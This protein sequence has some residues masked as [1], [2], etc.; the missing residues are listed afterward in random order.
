MRTPGPPPPSLLRV[1]VRQEGLLGSRQ[2]DAAGVTA[3]RRETLRCA[4]VLVPVVRGVHDAAALLPEL[5]RGPDHVR[6]RAAWLALLALG[7]DRAVATGLCALALH[8]VHGLPRRIRPEAALPDGSHRRPGGGILVRGVDPQPVVRVGGARAC[9]VAQ[10][11]ADAVG[12]LPRDSAVA[13]LDSAVHLGLL[14]CADLA[15]VRSLLAGRRGCRRAA[16]WWDLV[17]GRAE[18]PLETRARLQCVDA[19]VPPHDVQVPVRDRSGRVVARGDLGWW[20]ATRRLLVV[21]IDGAGPHGTPQALYRDRTRQ[22]AVLATGALLLRFTA[23]DVD[24]GLVPVEVR[25][26]LTASAP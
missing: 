12:G 5:D 16:G 22:N 26:H 21:E 2:C 14:P 9:T 19:G 8:G 20:L 10:A 7:P 6:R 25:R 1:A 4:G 11:L 17:D 23:A 3:Q 13:V 24:R 15:L 18:S